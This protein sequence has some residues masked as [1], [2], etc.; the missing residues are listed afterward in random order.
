MDVAPRSE[1]LARGAF[2]DVGPWV[3][4]AR[5]PWLGAVPAERERIAAARIEGCVPPTIDGSR[6]SDP[7][8]TARL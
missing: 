2:T 8:T 7:D 1:D 6:A 3:V 5:P 4:P